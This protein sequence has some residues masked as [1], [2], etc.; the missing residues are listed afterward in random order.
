M[1]SVHAEAEEGRTKCSRWHCDSRTY[2]L[3]VSTLSAENT[4]SPLHQTVDVSLCEDTKSNTIDAT[5]GSNYLF[6]EDVFQAVHTHAVHKDREGDRLLYISVSLETT[7]P[8]F[9][10]DV[11]KSRHSLPSANH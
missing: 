1:L 11:N 4:L 3:I 7:S 9:R 5:M 2:T 8:W 6:A 10:T